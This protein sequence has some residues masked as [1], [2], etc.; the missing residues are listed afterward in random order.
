MIELDNPAYEGFSEKGSDK[1]K[2]LVVG[3]QVPKVDLKVIESITSRPTGAYLLRQTTLPSNV[4]VAL[5]MNHHDFFE[6]L[7]KDLTIL[8]SS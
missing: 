3:P 4:E 2:K 5:E 8:P 6:G 7:L 1:G